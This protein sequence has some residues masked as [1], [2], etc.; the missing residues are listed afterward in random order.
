MY[1]Y[2]PAAPTPTEGVVSLDPGQ[3][4]LVLAIWFVVVFVIGAILLKR[5][6]A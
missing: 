6:D 2:A 5:R 1:S 3:G 4:L